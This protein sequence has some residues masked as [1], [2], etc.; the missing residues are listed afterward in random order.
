MLIQRALT[1]S[2]LREALAE[3]PAVLLTGPRQVGKTTL[4]RQLLAERPDA[5]YRD[6]EASADRRRMDDPRAFL[7]TIAG[8]LMILD[9][10]HPLPMLFAELRGEIDERRRQGHRSGQVLLLGSA[11]LDLTKPRPKR[12][13]GGCAIS[14]SRH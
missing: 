12:W 13:P 3:V 10:V 5:V 1:L 11:L 2:A 7:A 9:E 14:R 8:R 6:L 4:A